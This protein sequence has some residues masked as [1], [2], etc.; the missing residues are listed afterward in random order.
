MRCNISLRLKDRM[1]LDLKDLLFSAEKA[2][3]KALQK[4]CAIGGNAP[5]A[6]Q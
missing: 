5:Y 4:H 2:N 1:D 6:A 3:K